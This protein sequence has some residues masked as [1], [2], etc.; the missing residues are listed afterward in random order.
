MK[1]EIFGI[2]I[3]IAS[4]FLGAIITL[5]H[6]VKPLTS[7]LFFF[8]IPTIYMLL[9]RRSLPY[10]KLFL[11][12]LVVA[13]IMFFLDM[14]IIAN[15]GW[16]VPSNQLFIP[17]RF[18]GLVPLE[19]ILWFGFFFLFVVTFYEYYIERDRDK[20]LS[21]NFKWFILLLLATSLLVLILSLTSWFYSIEYIYLITCSIYMI[22][23]VVYA[24]IKRPE[25]IKKFFLVTVPFFFINLIHEITAIRAGQ[26]IFPGEYIGEVVLFGFSFPFEEFFFY[27]AIGAA[28]GLAYYEIFVD[29]MK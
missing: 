13:G 10:K 25:F 8:I 24:F 23:P 19:E 18:F 3:I 7:I 15:K 21:K 4:V 14:L 28:T 27:I 26:W 5:E 1:K 11:S 16:Y 17:W 20:V 29:D 22:P 9:T 2:I 12:T 6:E